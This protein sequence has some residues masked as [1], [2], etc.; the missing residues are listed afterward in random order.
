MGLDLTLQRLLVEAATDWP[1][2]DWSLRTRL[3]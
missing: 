3:A 1:E 2:V